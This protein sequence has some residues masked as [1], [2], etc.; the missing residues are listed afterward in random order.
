MKLSLN[1]LILALLGCSEYSGPDYPN[2][3]EKPS[4][5]FS[6]T[7][8]ICLIG[9]VIAISDTGFGTSP[10]NLRVRFSGGVQVRIDSATTTTLYVAVPFGAFSG[11]VTVVGAAQED[12]LPITVYEAYDPSALQM[13][14]YNLENP[15]DSANVAIDAGW[16]GTKHWNDWGVTISGD[17]VSFEIRFIPIPH[18]LAHYLVQF[19]DNGPD[20]LPTLISA[21]FRHYFGIDTLE[22]GILKIQ[23]WNT[24][25]VISGRFYAHNSTGYD[26][27]GFWYDFSATP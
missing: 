12:S 24:S 22:S 15:I 27:L 25:S 20:S 23:N 13:R 8:S 18:E 6:I 2:P 19:R 10:F 3:L 4:S 16:D 21:R 1:I 26:R 7:P 11:Y 5:K 9:D 14:W 17:T